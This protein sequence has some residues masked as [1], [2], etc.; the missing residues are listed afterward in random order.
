MFKHI[1]LPID[2]Q[3]TDKRLRNMAFERAVEFCGI[4]E[5]RLHILTVVPDMG[6]PIVNGH[7]PAETEDFFI[8]ESQKLLNEVV[9]KNVPEDMSVQQL[10][11]QGKAY[12]QILK[13]ADK[14]RADLIIMPAQQKRL[15]D[16]LIGSNASRVVRFAKC[17][18]LV[19]REAF[20]D[21]VVGTD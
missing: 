3:E 8:Q 1:L 14:V 15:Q 9:K 2:L 21:Q 13:M 5:A 20:D 6:S 17:S 10:L 19:V 12:K 11:A 7:F 18:V 4:Y 16:F